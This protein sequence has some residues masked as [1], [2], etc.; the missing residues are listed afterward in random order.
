AERIARRIAERLAP[1]R[2]VTL[3][4]LSGTWQPGTDA[5]AVVLVAAVR[6]GR[7]LPEARAFAAAWGGRTR[8]PLAVVSVCL[9]ARKPNRRTAVDNP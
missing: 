3:E 8:P 1:S 4:P 5:A 6:Y 2:P 7:H 9:T